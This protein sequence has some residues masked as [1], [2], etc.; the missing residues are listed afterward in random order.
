MVEQHIFVECARVIMDIQ[1]PQMI[2]GWRGV[3][4]IFAVFP[5]YRVKILKGPVTLRD[6]LGII[7]KSGE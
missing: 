2:M 6:V 4:I 1:V 7:E 3:S 5:N